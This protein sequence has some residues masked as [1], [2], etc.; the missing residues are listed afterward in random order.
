MTKPQSPV[1]TSQ[2]LA[3]KSVGKD[4]E[5][6]ERAAR[7]LVEKESEIESSWR[8]LA[9]NDF[10][11]F[12]RGIRIKAQD[13]PRML[14][15]VMAPFQRICF[16]DMADSIEAVR[17][18]QMP[19]VRRFWLE[20]TKK[21]SK[22]G[23]LAVIVTWLVAFG[24]NPLYGQIGAADRDQAGIVRD[25]ISDLLYY[26]P[27]LNDHMELVGNEIRGKLL[28]SDGSPVVKFDIESSDVAGSH[29]G[30]PDVLVVNEL[31]HISKFE[32]AETMMDNADGVAQGIVIIATN[33]GV[34]GGKAWKWRKA[35][36]ESEEWCVHILD[37]HAPWH[38]EKTLA[39]ARKRN[40]LSRY[41]RL[42][43]GLWV[44]GTGDAF[45][46]EQ[47]DKLFTGKRI[48]NRLKDSYVYVA[49]LDIGVNRD[50][51]GFMIVGIDISNKK[52]RLAYMRRWNPKDYPNKEIDLMAVE[53]TVRKY[54]KSFGVSCLLYD[55]HQA[56]LM[57]QRLKS[58]VM[59]RE[60]SFTAKNLTG[61]ANSLKQ[62]VE[63]TMIELWD[64]SDC[65]LRN[66][67]GKL[68]IV[69][70]SYGYK[71][72]ATRDE[73]GHAD[74]A[75]CLAIIAPAVIEMLGGK[76]QYTKDRELAEEE[77]WQDLTEEE[78][79]DL[80]D[81]FKELYDDAPS[82]EEFWFDRIAG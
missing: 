16:E 28:R 72:E 43:K 40:S 49:S 66:D 60:M 10:M 6:N 50:H 79:E 38:T 34:R 29:G 5:V 63:E 18:K 36:L 64:D 65:N 27:W 9:K 52:A 69:E 19:P 82:E 7:A 75:T 77:D 51:A 32:F 3:A 1:S 14:D 11:V 59:V 44:S 48:S 33:A 2:T 23:D 46:D 47:L 70:K 68:S 76:V 12:V 4:M 80:P 62:L 21:A 13:G 39:D 35:A 56:K 26:N 53:D 71:L 31:S 42:W 74:V 20:R 24:K 58:T 55:P 37:K 17:A 81:E 25:R 22:D 8:S 45:E 67:I 15:S 30:T 57:A 73:D 54:C 41:K 61:M 78:V